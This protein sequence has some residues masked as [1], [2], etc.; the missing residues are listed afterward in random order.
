[1][2]GCYITWAGGRLAPANYFN[3]KA[4]REVL[5]SGSCKRR[6]GFLVFIDMKWSGSKIKSTGAFDTL[7]RYSIEAQW[8]WILCLAFE[9]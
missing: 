2:S 7:S 3:A 6:S 9:S 4:G 8:L 1:M 5:R